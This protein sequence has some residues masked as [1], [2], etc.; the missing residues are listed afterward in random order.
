MGGACDAEFEGADMHEVAGKGGEHLMSTTDED[1]KT[2][3]DQMA[4]SKPE[5]QA[6][7]FDWF[8]GVWDS[9]PDSV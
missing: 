4:T 2:M 6:K 8:K 5:D 1:H 9:K 7:W 3:R